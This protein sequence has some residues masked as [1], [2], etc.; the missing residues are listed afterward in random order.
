MSDPRRLESGETRILE[1]PGASHPTFAGP[2]A[3]HM[4]PRFP[5]AWRTWFW[6]HRT[7]CF[8]QKRPFAG[9]APLLPHFL[10]GLLFFVLPLHSL[11]LEGVFDRKP[12]EKQSVHALKVLAFPY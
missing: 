3:A 6:S 12:L 2:D 4:R 9:E 8:L 7:V 5:D 1:H 11:P 10:V